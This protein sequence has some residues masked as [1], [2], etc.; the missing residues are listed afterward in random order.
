MN[1]KILEKAKQ[2]IDEER[3]YAEELRELASKFKH[4]LLQTLILGIAYDSEK[5]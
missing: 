4:L 5:T 1:S 3:H 2:M